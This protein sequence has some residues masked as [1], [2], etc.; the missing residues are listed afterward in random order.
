MFERSAIQRDELALAGF[1]IELVPVGAPLRVE[2]HQHPVVATE[3]QHSQHIIAETGRVVGEA[4]ALPVGDL[5]GHED[6]GVA[7][8]LLANEHVWIRA[9]PHHLPSIDARSTPKRSSEVQSASAS[10]KPVTPRATGV[11]SVARSA[12]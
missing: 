11:G 4:V 5:A 12:R 7:Q 8:T 2:A 3:V 9:L 6:E 10:S 1:K